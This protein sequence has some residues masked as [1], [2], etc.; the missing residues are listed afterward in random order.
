MSWMV[1]EGKEGDYEALR[2]LVLVLVQTTG[3][4]G[5]FHKEDEELEEENRK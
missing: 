2:V 4:H 3:G 5:G 1:G